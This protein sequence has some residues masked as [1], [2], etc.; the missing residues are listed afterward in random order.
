M[1]TKSVVDKEGDYCSSRFLTAKDIQVLVWDMSL[2]WELDYRL[3]IWVI[4]FHL[5][6][7]L[8]DCLTNTYQVAIVC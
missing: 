8:I 1:S 2:S 6:S 7:Q 3:T 5:F 4:A